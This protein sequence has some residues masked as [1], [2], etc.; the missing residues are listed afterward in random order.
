MIMKSLEPFDSLQKAALTVCDHETMCS[1]QTFLGGDDLDPGREGI[2][3]LS[4]QDPDLAAILSRWG[5]PPLWS[6]PPGFATL[7][8][9]ILEQQVSLAS[10][11][12]VLDRLTGLC[13]PLEPAPFLGFDD[14]TLRSIGFSRQK[15]SYCRHLAEALLSGELKLEDLPDQDDSTV[16]KRLVK[17]KGIGPWTAD[18]YL[19]MVLA[20]QDV[21]PAGDLAL[22]QAVCDLKQLPERP[23]PDRLTLIAERWRPWQTVAARLLWHD[24]L[25]RR[26]RS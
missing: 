10:A 2:E 3:Y 17:I 6:R 19:M 4:R 12:A 8:H 20:R 25:C 22:A 11:R 16:R 18:V 7:V 9:M 15:T 21:W 13:S 5:P 14:Q 24:Y 26:G 23:T 1:T